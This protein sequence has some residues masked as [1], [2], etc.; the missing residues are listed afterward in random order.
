MV[1]LMV[2]RLFATVLSIGG[3]QRRE[4]SSVTFTSPWPFYASPWSLTTVLNLRH[5][6]T[7]AY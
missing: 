6:E 1:I 2:G 5:K 3:Q 7:S 4:A